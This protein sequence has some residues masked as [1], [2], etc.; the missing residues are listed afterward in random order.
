MARA[1]KALV[2]PAG[3][4][5]FSETF[6]WTSKTNS[7]VASSRATSDRKTTPAKT[8]R[9]IAF[10]TPLDSPLIFLDPVR[11]RRA[12]NANVAKPSQHNVSHFITRIT[13]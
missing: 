11:G 12:L 8:N 6:L 4:I 3:M 2:I 5:V 13:R 10:F 1:T 7:W 9:N